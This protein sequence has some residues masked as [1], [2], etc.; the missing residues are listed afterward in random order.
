M[1]PCSGGGPVTILG[2]SHSQN[3]ASACSFQLSGYRLFLSHP[4]LP[5][6]RAPLGT[7]IPNVDPQLMHHAL[8][9]FEHLLGFI[10]AAPFDASHA[11][12]MRPNARSAF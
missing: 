8:Y 4:A 7:L 11:V 6:F 2:S 12:P 10:P 1:T 3:Q 5:V 9:P